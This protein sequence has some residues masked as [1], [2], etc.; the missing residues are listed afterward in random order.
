RSANSLNVSYTS[1]K[2][3][4]GAFPITIE[5]DNIYMDLDLYKQPGTDPYKYTVDIIYPDNWAVTDSSELN[6][7]IS[8]LTGQ[9]EMKK[10]K[11]L[12]LSWQY[13]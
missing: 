13:K 11:K 7:A 2:T 9:L 8:S 3:S 12:N 6:H 1:T 10:D 5:G 4:S